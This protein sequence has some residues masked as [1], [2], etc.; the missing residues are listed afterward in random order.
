LQLLKKNNVK[1]FDDEG[2]DVDED[3]FLAYGN[4]SREFE[5]DPLL[6]A[7]INNKNKNKK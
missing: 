1:F 6:I 5:K 4:L 7:I 3:F 2:C